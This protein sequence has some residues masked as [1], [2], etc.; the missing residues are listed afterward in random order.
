MLVEAFVALLAA[1][2]CIGI[3]VR[4]GKANSEP[5]KPP[6]IVYKD[7]T[8]QQLVEYWFGPQDKT[9]LRKRIC[10]D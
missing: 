2:A 6:V 1:A 8:D 7:A 9:S 10:K 4:I 3:G 5:P